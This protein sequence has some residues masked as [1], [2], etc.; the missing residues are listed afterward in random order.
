M[1]RNKIAAICCSMALLLC[2]CTFQSNTSQQ[3]TVTLVAKST[4]TEFWLSVFAGA[5]A[6]ATE[7]NLD[8]NI[9]GPDAEE[10]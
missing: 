2:G 5:E 10:D 4:Q 3:Y 8:L 1:R 6:A 9:I 7:Y